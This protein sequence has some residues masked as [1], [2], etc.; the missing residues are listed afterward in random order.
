MVSVEADLNLDQRRDLAA[1]CVRSVD[2]TS[3][4]A[5][6]SLDVLSSSTVPDSIEVYEDD[7]KISDDKFS[8]VLN[9]YVTLEY[10]KGEDGFTT[11]DGFPGKFRGHF[12]ETG[13]AVIDELTVDTSSFYE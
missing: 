3:F 11:S 4:D 6:N 8:G 10:G 13:Q 1:A 12:D 5:W 7:I 9:V 2:L